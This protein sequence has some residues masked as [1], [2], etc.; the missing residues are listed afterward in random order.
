MTQIRPK[1]YVNRSEKVEKIRETKCDSGTQPTPPMLIDFGFTRFVS[2]LY[3]SVIWI[4]IVV[5][6]L[7]GYGITVIFGLYVMSK[8]GAVGLLV[9]LLATLIAGLYLFLTRMTLE[10]LFRI[11]T[12]LR[13]IRDT[14]ETSDNMVNL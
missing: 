5:L 3:I 11:E 6:T 8:N 14:Y 9:I 7:L 13:T 12:H 2:N 4:V 10:M 1:V